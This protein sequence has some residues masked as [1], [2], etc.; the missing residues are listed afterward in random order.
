MFIS[1]DDGVTASETRPAGLEQC[2]RV[3]LP[4]LK[5]MENGAP[6]TAEAENLWGLEDQLCEALAADEAK[7]RLVGRIT[8][9]AQREIVFQCEDVSAIERNRDKIQS[10]FSEYAMELSPHDGWDFFD[11][12]IAPEFFDRLYMADAEVV[13]GL[14]ES[15][16]NQDALHEVEYTFEGPVE[17]LKK[18]QASL[19]QGGYSD[20][21][22]SEE[23][24]TLMMRKQSTLDLFEISEMSVANF[25]LANE[26]GG[27]M[28]GWGAAVVSG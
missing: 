9:A 12:C 11:E 7:C 17:S 5:P 20:G 4:I 27:E 24:E 18:I 16:S 15:G 28:L 10:L 2:V 14:I 26:S 1:F 8:Y 13:D 3:C 25:E 22:F 21:Y 23:D 19:L 6:D